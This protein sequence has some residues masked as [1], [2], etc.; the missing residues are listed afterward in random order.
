[1]NEVQFGVRFYWGKTVGQISMSDEDTLG[2]LH[3]L[4]QKTLGWDSDHLYE[5]IMDGT[6]RNKHK[7]YSCKADLDY[8][9]EPIFSGF[10]E[11][12]KIISLGLAQG[13]RFFYHFDYGEDWF[14]EIRVVKIRQIFEDVIPKILKRNGKMPAQY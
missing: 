13:Q 5:F 3:D 9:A 14:F 2:V 7:V 10:A 8:A 4:I 6:P 1:M 11:E 12:T